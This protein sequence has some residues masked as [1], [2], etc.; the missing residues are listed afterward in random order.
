[1]HNYC[2]KYLNVYATLYVEGLYSFYAKL[3]GAFIF[4]KYS[5][6]HRCCYCTL[7]T[8]LEPQAEP[9]TNDKLY[10]VVPDRIIYA[11]TL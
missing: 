3:N 7:P 10:F 2:M 8:A 5:I 11:L 6:G 1:M 4:M 9:G